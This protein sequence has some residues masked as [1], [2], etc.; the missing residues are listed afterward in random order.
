MCP[1]QPLLHAG[2]Q[3]WKPLYGT[4]I[5]SSCMCVH[6]WLKDSRYFPWAE[7][8]LTLYMAA[9]VVFFLTL[10]FFSL[11]RLHGEWFFLIIYFFPNVIL[12]CGYM[13]CSVQKSTLTIALPDMFGESAIIMFRAGGP[14][15][16]S[17]SFL[18]KGPGQLVAITMAWCTSILVTQQPLCERRGVWWAPY[19]NSHPHTS[20]V[21]Q[22]ENWTFLLQVC[23]YWY[24]GWMGQ[25]H[26][27]HYT[28]L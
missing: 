3:C 14:R 21:E 17:I 1:L 18:L 10:S 26:V 2:R 28:R 23:A 4:N 8:P 20:R 16:A 24:K 27:Q 5:F 13:W 7:N 12:Y 22:W 25:F 19:G 9:H 11:P 6:I 15:Q